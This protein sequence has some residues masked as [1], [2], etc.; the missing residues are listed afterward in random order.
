MA[1]LQ[2][3]LKEYVVTANNPEYGGD[4][5][6]INSKF[7]ELANIDPI[8]LQEYVKTAN[9]PSYAG[10]YNI[11]NGKF[12][13][14]FTPVTPTTT[15]TTTT[16]TTTPTTTVAPS[17]EEVK[18]TILSQLEEM[19]KN[20]VVNKTFWE[21]AGWTDKETGERVN[22]SRDDYYKKDG[23]WYYKRPSDGKE[24]KLT[25]GKRYNELV[26]EEKRTKLIKEK[27]EIEILDRSKNAVPPPSPLHGIVLP[28]L[29]SYSEIWGS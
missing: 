11:I 26:A 20:I 24:F 17:V 3:I 8:V 21:N 19:Q 22:V 16:P 9:N 29:N 1:D 25:K 6:V 10:N 18:T 4:Y 13:E 28:K 23:N 12:P 5:D 7:P 2:S 27:K 15:P 14:F